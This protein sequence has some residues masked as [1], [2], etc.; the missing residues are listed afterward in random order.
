MKYTSFRNIRYC[1]PVVVAL[2]ALAL[3][4]VA[5]DPNRKDS[6]EAVGAITAPANAPAANSIE[7]QARETIIPELKLVDATVDEALILISKKSGI[8]IVNKGK[9]KARLTVALTK[10]P[11]ADAIEY[12][13]S[14][15]GLGL[16]YGKDGVLVN[17]KAP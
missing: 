13:V 1:L 12:V 4:S 6:G 14:L 8:K 10:I 16:K 7:K 9:S 15:A 2:M 5:Q 17:G 3:R 11:A